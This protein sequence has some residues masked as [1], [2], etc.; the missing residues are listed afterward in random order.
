MTRK[1]ER[2]LDA[3]YKYTNLEEKNRMLADKQREIIEN[4]KK[5]ISHFEEQEATAAR[6]NKNLRLTLHILKDRK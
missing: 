2:V 1:E 6:K 3:V 4:A 5:A